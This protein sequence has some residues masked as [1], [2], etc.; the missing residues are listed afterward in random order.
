MKLFIVESPGKV[1]KIQG[2]LGPSY[3]V[4]ASFGHVRDL[5]DREMGIAPPDFTPEYVATERGKG[6][7]AKIRAAAKDAEEVYLATDPDRE[8][9]AIAWHIEDALGL[10][11][12]KRVSY[13]EI[14][15]QAV[16]TALRSTRGIDRHLVAA[17]ECRRV[18]DRLV[19]YMVSPAL[20][21]QSGDKLSAGRVQSP[22]VRLVVDR[23]RAIRDFKVTAH[24][25]VD[26]VFEAMEHITD[27]WKAS[28]LP[29]EGWLEEGQDYILDKTLAEQV[30]AVSSV[31]VLD[32]TESESKTAPP[33]PFTTST[34]QQAASA[35][36]KINPA[37]CMALAQRLYEN[38][39][40][41]YMRTDS[42]NLSEEA[43]AE[44]RSWAAQHDYPVPAA[45]RTWKSKEGAQE[46]HEAIRPTHIEAEEA[47]ENEE[48]QA[49]YRL[50]RLRA[51]ASQLEE[52]VYAVRSLRLEGEAADRKAVFEAKGRTLVQP[53][54]KVLVTKDQTDDGEEED[55]NQIPKL[56]ARLSLNP[57]EG[58]LLS[59]KT[60]PPARYTEA[61]LIR[62]LEKRGI[63]R[64]STYAAILENITTTHQYL[65]LEKRNLVPT[66]KGEKAVDAMNGT[67]AFCDYDFTKKMEEELDAIAEGKGR[68]QPLVAESH[69]QLRAEIDAYIAVTSPKCPECGQPLRHLVKAAAKGHKGYNF[70]GCSGHPDCPATFADAGGVPGERQDTKPKA[71]P[72][73]YVCAACGK[74]LI[75][76]QGEKNGRAF[77][78]WGCSGFPQCKASFANDA[79]KPGERQDTKAK[80]AASE[81]K[82]PKCKGDLARRQGTS[83]KTGKAYDFYS[84]LG[85]CKATYNPTEDGTPEFEGRQRK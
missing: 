74:P 43:I 44:I 47:G 12:A 19:G 77:D 10:K 11:G 33:A 1:K 17:Q 21:R 9:E 84:C 55:E 31:V 37:A 20:S 62:E 72:S 26:L 52:A 36:L 66:E 75:H 48:E 4:M 28:W 50:I 85:K 69:K 42:P 32:C 30:A 13:T 65:G 68:Y 5:P 24:F 51:I 15:E 56:E 40:I 35:A 61:S 81:H 64:P 54:W 82:C 63:G 78:F 39:H 2:F 59:K 34:M 73:E 57:Q 3:R 14:T 53:G 23:E 16:K 41:T 79:G 38:G 76:R 46:A 60:R 80:K 25:G 49:L 70:W 58:K 27:G 29:K 45:P 18:L 67:F 8:G 22:A 83:Q 7:L 6:I 71:E